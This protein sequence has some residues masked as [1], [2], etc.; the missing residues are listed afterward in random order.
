MNH[1][2][3]FRR[4]I[5]IINE[6]FSHVDKSAVT[7]DAVEIV[8]STEVA[9]RVIYPQ[10]VVIDHNTAE[11]T[12]LVEGLTTTDDVRLSAYRLDDI[13]AWSYK[14]AILNNV[15]YK[16]Q[17]TRLTDRVMRVNGLGVGPWNVVS[18]EFAQPTHTGNVPMVV[19]M[20]R[21]AAV[22]LNENDLPYAVPTTLK[23]VEFSVKDRNKLRMAKEFTASISGRGYQEIEFAPGLNVS[24]MALFMHAFCDPTHHKEHGRVKL[25]FNLSGS[26][27]NPSTYHT[28][29]KSH[30]HHFV[31]LIN[32][33]LKHAGLKPVTDLTP[34][35]GADDGMI[36]MGTL[37]DALKIDLV[38]LDL[39]DQLMEYCQ[40]GLVK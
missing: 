6:G 27:V 22:S 39:G 24:V 10:R 18:I 36:V 35:W 40:N 8:R 19:K 14:N 33:M 28:E 17:L 26:S 11:L 37:N 30:E 7:L 25:F 5:N 21:A 3:Q 23:G 4:I 13:A 16:N 9:D 31:M 1:N 2:E 15:V 20:K 32:A 34:Y 12:A 29:L 38:S